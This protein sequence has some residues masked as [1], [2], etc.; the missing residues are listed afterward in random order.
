MLE[1]LTKFK[2]LPPAIR[3][4]VSGEAAIKK[5]NELEAKYGVSLADVVI[6]VMV[7][8]LSLNSLPGF[9]VADLKMELGQ[10]G[11]LFEEIKSQIFASVNEYLL[12]GNQASQAVNQTV[13]SVENIQAAGSKNSAFFFDIEDEEDVK[14][15]AEASVAGPIAVDYQAET[16][17]IIKKLDL[18]FGSELLIDRL[19][20]L[21]ITYLKGIRNRIDVKL[22]FSKPIDQ[23]GVSLDEATVDAIL[24]ELESVKIRLGKKIE[25]I[26]VDKAR[27]PVPEDAYKKGNLQSLKNLGARDI[28]YDFAAAVK[29]LEKPVEIKA[30]EE[31]KEIEAPKK[32]REQK[33]E[34]LVMAQTDPYAWGRPKE[35]TG[36]VLMN[37]IKKEAPKV[38]GP[39]DELQ[40]LDLVVFRRLAT[41][42]LEAINKI[43]EKIEL[44]ELESYGKRLD[45]IKAWRLSSVNKIYLKIG[46]EAMKTG[47][48]VADVISALSNQSSCLSLVEFEAIMKLNRELRF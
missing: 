31:L 34:P 5:I 25:V 48:S 37:D 8:D 21:M 19:R 44:L 26:N 40:Y 24:N 38:M 1:Y 22:S 36:K 3:E 9:F 42:P 18:S 27:I 47:R 23:G 29:K 14:K 16:A 46:E 4:A 45:G 11:A 30:A 41:N 35:V 2:Q 13:P 17:A 33:I 39:I 6:R 10:A 7:R 20:G 28:D 12:S 43:K 32:L 15:H